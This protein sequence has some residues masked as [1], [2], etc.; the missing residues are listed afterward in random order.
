[1]GVSEQR[2]VDFDPAALLQALTAVR[3]VNGALGLRGDRIARVAFP[4]DREAIGVIDNNGLPVAEPK[5][6]S[7]AALLIFRIC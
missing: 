6:E 3:R 2:M 7:L 1:M 4:P 5:A